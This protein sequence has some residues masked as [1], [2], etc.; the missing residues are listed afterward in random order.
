LEAIDEPSCQ[1]LEQPDCCPKDYYG[2]M[3]KCWNHDP[4]HR[5]KFSDLIPLL[6]EVEKLKY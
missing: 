1:R 5:P 2:L 4:V 3:L 6:P